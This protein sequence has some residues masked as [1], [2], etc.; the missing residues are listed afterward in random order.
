MPFDS[1][2]GHHTGLELL[3]GLRLVSTR[4]ENSRVLVELLG[5]EPALRPVTNY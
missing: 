5:V 1:S 3:T 2:L 4:I